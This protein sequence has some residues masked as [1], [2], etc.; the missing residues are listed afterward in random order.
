MVLGLPIA[1]ELCEAYPLSLSQ[2]A[3][4]FHSILGILSKRNVLGAAI[5]SVAILCVYPQIMQEAV[6]GGMR[7]RRKGTRDLR[8]PTTKRNQNNPHSSGAWASLYPSY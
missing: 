4:L 2:G 5:I 6:G 3:A 7:A 1:L 8:K